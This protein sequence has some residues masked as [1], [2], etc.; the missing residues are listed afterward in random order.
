MGDET[1]SANALDGDL[2]QSPAFDELRATNCALLGA[3]C[4]P[5]PELGLSAGAQQ[6]VG[7]IAAQQAMALLL[8]ARPPLCEELDREQPLGEVVEALVA[9]AP[10]DAQDAGL[11]KRLEDRA[12]LIGRPPVPVDGRTRLDIGC[13]HWAVR[14]DPLE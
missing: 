14:A 13:A 9:V 8:L 1:P 12:H 11:G 7:A 6:A 3:P 10:G 5:E 4:D 2:D